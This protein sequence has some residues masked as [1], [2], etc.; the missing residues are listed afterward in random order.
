M[1][2]LIYLLV[3]LIATTIGAIVGLGGG[4]IIK[5]VLD[6][7]GYHDILT[8]G[9]LTTFTVLTMALVSTIKHIKN[10][11]KLSFK[12]L[13]IASGSIVGGVLGNYIFDLMVVGSNNETIKLTQSIIFIVMISL[14]LLFLKFKKRITSQHI[15]SKL[16]MFISG[17]ILGSIASFLGVGGGAF[18]VVVLIYLFSF[19]AKIAAINS[20]LI[21]LFSQTAKVV[22]I[23]LT[24]GFGGYDLSM[25]KVMIPA[26]IL[27]GLIGSSFNK[28]MKN[29]SIDL[30]FRGVLFFIIIINTYNALTVI[31]LV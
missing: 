19:D 10:K 28:K 12:A 27:G 9:I 3:A 4:V 2:E 8:I 23:S 6:V 29:E 25:L 17:V 11:S 30:L 1:I 16:V 24:T 26:A 31:F 22:S 20:L 13:F 7:I 18:N 21:K 14:V 5:P 15:N